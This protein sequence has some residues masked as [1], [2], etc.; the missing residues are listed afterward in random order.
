MYH[1]PYPTT[2][3]GANPSYCCPTCDVEPFA[4]DTYA[5]SW[6]ECNCVNPSPILIDVAGNGFDLTNAQNGVNFDIK[7]SGTPVQ[8]SWTAPNSDDSWLA[9]DTD[10]NGTID[11]GRELFGNL[12]P[13]T[14]PSPGVAA[15]GFLALAEYDKTVNGGNEDDQIT[16]QDSIFSSLRLWQDTNHNGISEPSELKTLNQLGLAQIELRYKE[17]K[18]TDQYGN[19][20]KYRAKVK[21]VH[22]AQV[23]RWAWDVFLLTQ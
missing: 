8:V 11:S 19:K 22:G 13:Q 18:R 20:F 4:C 23:G 2:A 21:D 15:N 6:I 16:A 1:C 3:D 5:W 17:S 12:T 7:A 10:G 14:K 9:L